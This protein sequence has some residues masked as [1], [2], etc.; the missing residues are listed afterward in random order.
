MCRKSVFKK[1]DFFSECFFFFMQ[2]GPH[3]FRRFSWGKFIIFTNHVKVLAVLVSL[4]TFSPINNLNFSWNDNC[5]SLFHLK[6]SFDELEAEN[7]CS[8]CSVPS[9]CLSQRA[10]KLEKYIASLLS[11]HLKIKMYTFRSCMSSIRIIRTHWL[12]FIT[13]KF[14]IYFD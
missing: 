12:K 1:F 4:L 5:L 6:E 9:K 14:G 11:Q 7:L 10:D 2:N 13:R 3:S 8:F